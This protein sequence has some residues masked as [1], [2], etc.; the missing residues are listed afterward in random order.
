MQGADS[1]KVQTRGAVCV[2]TASCTSQIWCRRAQNRGD[3]GRKIGVDEGHENGVDE[4]HEDGAKG[5]RMATT[6]TRETHGMGY[7]TGFGR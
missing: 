5:G 7:C 1:E 6:D 3:E 4:R 2:P